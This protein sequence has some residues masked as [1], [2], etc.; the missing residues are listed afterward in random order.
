MEPASDF[1]ELIRTLTSGCRLMPPTD[2]S[3]WLGFSS[4]GALLLPVS[5][6]VPHTVYQTV[7]FIAYAKQLVHFTYEP[8]RG[9]LPESTSHATPLLEEGVVV[10]KSESGSEYSSYSDSDS[11]LSLTELFLICQLN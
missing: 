9:R 6:R 2:L 5:V 7:G 3:E 4:P 8:I 10:S 11:C 1:V